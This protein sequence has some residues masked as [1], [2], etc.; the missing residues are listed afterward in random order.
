MKSLITSMLKNIASRFI[1]LSVN[2][3]VSDYRSNFIQYQNMMTQVTI[4]ADKALM[5]FSIAA[6]AA[7]AALND[8]VFG[9]YGRL[10]FITFAC[11]IAVATVTIIGYSI[12]KTIIKDARDIMTRN[13]KKSLTTPLNEGFDK[14]RF[15]RLSVF[16]NY[17]STTLFTLGMIS[18]V[19]LMALYIKGV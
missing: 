7:L 10:S 4:E 14:I 12:S 13:Y 3:R 16:L 2:E 6:L 8:A 19:I 18:F 17:A 15:R 5:T 9:P 11:F 1:D